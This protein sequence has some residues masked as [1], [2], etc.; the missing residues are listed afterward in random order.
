M[1]TLLT[2]ILLS[3]ASLHARD[4][5]LKGATVYPSPDDPLLTGAIIVIHNNR[6]RTVGPEASV[7]IPRHAQVVD[8][9]GKFI[10]AGFWNSHVHILTPGLLHGRDSNS[11]DLDR[12]L[13]AMFN[14]WGFTTVFDISSVLD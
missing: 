2:L 12:E 5:V 13:D 11:A 6:I 10:V 9:T 4:L 3:A 8:C 1:R 14:R 7:R